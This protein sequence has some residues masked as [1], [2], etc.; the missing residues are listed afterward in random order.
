[1]EDIAANT[2]IFKYT[3]NMSKIFRTLT[4]LLVT[5]LASC[6]SYGQ[7]PIDSKYAKQFEK[8]RSAYNE[9]DNDQ[10]MKILQN[11]NGKDPNIPHV[12]VLMFQIHQE[13][14]DFEKAQDDLENVIAIDPT[15][16]PVANLIL[17]R[18][19]QS[20]GMYD[21]AAQHLEDYLKMPNISAARKAEAEF[22]LISCQF[23][24]DAMNNPVPF[25][26]INMGEEL[27][28]EHE[29]YFPTVTANDKTIL[30]T[31]RLP[32]DNTE[33]QQED[34]YI[35]NKS[36]E[37]WQMARPL[38]SVNTSF[39]EGAPSI[40]PDG[41]WLVFTACENVYEEYGGGRK[42]LGSC[43]LFY[44]FREGNSWS[45]P[46]NMGPNINSRNWET[47]PSISADGR[48]LYF[49]RGKINERRVQNH[50]IYTSTLGD[51][52]QWTKAVK[53]TEKINSP[54]NES[55]V[56]IHPDGRTLYFTS[57]GHIGMG[58]EDIYISRMQENGEWGTPL[59]LGYPINT[60]NNEN[61]LV[62]NATGE[63][64]MLSSDREGGFGGMDLYQFNLYEAA[65]P[66][67][68][69]YMEGNVFD[70]KTKASVSARFELIDLKTGKIAI[71][72]YSNPVDGKF[73]VSLP[74]GHEYALNVSHPDYMFYSEHFELTGGDIT[75]PFLVDVALDQIEKGSSIVLENIFF[76]TDKYELKSASN[77]EIDKLYSF[78]KRNAE[79][80]VEIIGHTDNQGSAA[81]NKTLSLN[82]AQAVANA[83]VAKGIE[84]TRIT[85]SGMGSEKPIAS[86]DTED[87]RAKNRR[88]ELLIR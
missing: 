36:G 64:A 22:K 43:D 71:E 9:H 49:I 10:A 1:M 85:S 33:R 7:P 46:R 59:N 47:Q 21:E 74:A 67:Y 83:L 70:A 11:I 50:D 32:V 80:N 54:G 12:H 38:K 84:A 82:R 63:V 5:V 76:D 86:N 87:G 51:D 68:V 75:D 57:D 41:E 17:G 61:S 4:V 8:A 31:R 15:F 16:F 2:Q 13:A 42:G 65:R 28:T 3:L 24:K 88:T 69:T 77:V 73:L 23:A 66:T 40:A 27:N 26:P 44:S 53:L 30:F 55:S 52:G 72:S 39:N 19:K 58:G 25:D 29:E 37:D 78:L 14:Q 20:E 62:V 79:V 48:T 81:H 45:K 35:A 18:V 34:F 6:A 56:M 60:F